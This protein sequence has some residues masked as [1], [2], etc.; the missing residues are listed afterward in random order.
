MVDLGCLGA[1]FRLIEL[2]TGNR[3]NPGFVGVGPLVH[4]GPTMEMGTIISVAPEFR[5]RDWR[6][7]SKDIE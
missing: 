1:L 3:A 7:T 2:D 5:S 4:C 6:E